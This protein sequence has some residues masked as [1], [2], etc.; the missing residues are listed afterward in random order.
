MQDKL[1]K[2]REIEEIKKREEDFVFLGKDISP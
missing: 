2:D 1:L